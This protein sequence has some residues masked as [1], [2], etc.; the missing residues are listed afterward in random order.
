MQPV[1][2]PG[3][4]DRNSAP[5]NWLA[6]AAVV[7]S[8]APAKSSRAPAPASTRPL[9]TVSPRASKPGAVVRKT[10][11]PPSPCGPRRSISRSRTLATEPAARPPTRRRAAT[12]V[13]PQK[14]SGAS[15]TLR[16]NSE[17]APAVCLPRMP[18]SRPA[19]NQR[20]S[21]TR[22]RWSWNAATA[23]SVAGP[24]SPGSS[25]EQ[26]CPTAVRRRCRSRTASPVCPR[27]IAAA[28]M[29]PGARPSG[30]ELG[31]VLEELTLALGAHEAL[32]GLTGVEHHQGR[33]A[34]DVVTHRRLRVVVDVELRD[35]QLVLV[36]GRDL[37]ERR[38]DHLAGTAPLGPEVDEHRGL[39]GADGFVERVVREV[40][41]AVVRAHGGP[42]GQGRLSVATG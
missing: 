19:S 25:A 39:G 17:T 3:R 22:L 36:L 20:P 6:A 12:V 38:C 35:A 27:S 7:L 14:P 18:C 21:T 24:N 9:A 32:H 15:P 2:V 41:D 30:D 26:S 23:A 33:D 5:P 34:H 4:S 28:V 29:T 37:L 10:R 11:L 40:H 16:W 31:E 13:Q 8:S 1:P 42:F